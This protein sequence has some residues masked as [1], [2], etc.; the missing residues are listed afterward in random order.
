MRFDVDAKFPW[1]AYDKF[2]YRRVSDSSIL[3]VF[4]P[5][6]TKIPRF[7]VLNSKAIRVN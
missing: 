4:L 7:F 1:S 5:E 3:Q 2:W 6:K